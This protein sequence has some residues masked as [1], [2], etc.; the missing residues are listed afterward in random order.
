M[1]QSN[2]WRH[3]RNLVAFPQEGEHFVFMRAQVIKQVSQVF[4]QPAT[5]ALAIQSQH[6]ACGL[7]EFDGLLCGS[8]ISTSTTSFFLAGELETA[9][10]PQG[11]LHAGFFSSSHSTL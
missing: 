9:T 2:A 6:A 11:P 7:D 4:R 5:D 10:P 1:Y 3:R 8:H